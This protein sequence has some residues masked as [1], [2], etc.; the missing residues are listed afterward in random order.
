MMD[1]RLIRKNS[2]LNNQNKV[3]STLIQTYVTSEMQNCD[4]YAFNPSTL[5]DATI[6]NNAYKV[7]I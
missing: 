3:Q 5:K 1:N 7:L 6:Q 2:L 4:F